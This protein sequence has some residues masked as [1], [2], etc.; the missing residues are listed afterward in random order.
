MTLRRPTAR[1]LLLS[2]LGLLLAQPVA[3]GARAGGLPAE[4]SCPPGLESGRRLTVSDE[5]FATLAPHLPPEVAEQRSAFFFDGMQLEIGPCQ[6]RYAPPAFWDE[7]TRK[8]AAAAKLDAQGNL[9]DYGAGWPFPPDRIRPDDPAAGAK[10]A[11]DFAWR[12][13]GAGPHGELVIHELAEGAKRSQEYSGNW[14][15]QLTRHRADLAASGYAATAAPQYLWVAG[16]RFRRP[17]RAAN[18][19]WRQFRSPDALQDPRRADDIFV[20]VPNI[21]AT[22]RSATAWTDGLFVPRYTA[23]ELSSTPVLG[24]ETRPRRPLERAVGAAPSED[25]GRGLLGLLYRP[26]A[27]TW[28]VS[29]T[30]DVVAPQNVADRPGARFDWAGY[31][32]IDLAKYG[33]RGVAFDGERWDVRRAI[34]LEGAPRDPARQVSRLTLWLDMETLQPLYVIDRNSK[35]RAFQVGVLLY[36]WSGD[37]EGYGEVAP[38]VAADVLDPVAESFLAT[39]PGGTTWRRESWGVSSLPVSDEELRGLASTTRLKTLP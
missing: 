21:R 12:Y 23:S 33:P 15:L 39:G 8:T 37:A 35:G 3:G 16:G 29:G 26:N 1:R 5:T 14:Y 10:W 6:R 4:G 28:T 9:L 7:A 36:S 30:R 13:R 32:K 19:A 18:L 24:G 31:Q 25:I 2:T 27:Y 17:G 22:R 20:Y 11:W 38:G 34:V